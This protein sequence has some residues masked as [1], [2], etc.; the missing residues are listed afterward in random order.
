MRKVRIVTG[1]LTILVSFSTVVYSQDYNI[2]KRRKGD[3]SLVAHYKFDDGRGPRCLDLSG[4]VN[5]GS[6]RGGPAGKGAAIGKDIDW[7]VYPDYSIILYLAKIGDRGPN[8]VVEGKENSALKFDGIDDWV[9]VYDSASLCPPDEIT[10]E[11]WIKT[12]AAA[13]G[14]ILCKY[15]GYLLETEKGRIRFVLD[16]MEESPSILMGK[17]ELPSAT[18]VHIAATFDGSRLKIYLNGEVDGSLERAGPICISSANLK[19]GYKDYPSQRDYF[20]GVI[21]EVRI[22]SRA[23]TQD[24]VKTHY[25]GKEL[26]D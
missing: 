5:H 8:W 2:L 4:H 22:Y 12:P 9:E 19:I 6:L 26:E 18:W 7:T 15:T 23:L 24:E 25:E 10:I 17:T 14:P 11:A 13:G 1:V 3:P 16:M 21:D 20:Q